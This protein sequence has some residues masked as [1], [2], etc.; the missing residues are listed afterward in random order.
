MAIEVF[1]LVLTVW[2][3]GKNVSGSVGDAGALAGGQGQ[4]EF[5]EKMSSPEPRPK[6]WP[7]VSQGSSREWQ[8]LPGGEKGHGRC[9][10]PRHP[11]V[12]VPPW[13]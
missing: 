13:H 3:R 12:H 1:F 4:G 10:L 5:L 2:K 9:L 6:A 11:W 8:R 7:W